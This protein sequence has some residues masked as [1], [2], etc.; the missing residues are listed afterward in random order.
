MNLLLRAGAM[1]LAFLPSVASTQTGTSVQFPAGWAP[2][3]SICVKQGDGTC[4]PVGTTNPMPVSGGTGGSGGASASNQ[5]IGNNR[6][7]DL[8]APATGSANQRL[9]LINMTLG[10]PF[11]AGGS[12]GNTAFGATQSASWNLVNIT[13]TISLPT[14]AATA[15]NQVSTQAAAGVLDW[16]C[17]VSAAGL[18]SIRW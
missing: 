5:V 2:S 11:Q 9:G 12:I 15:A 14:G 6:L 13:D 3:T 7:G 1:T 16:A 18:A 4:A 17:N 8:S 10:T